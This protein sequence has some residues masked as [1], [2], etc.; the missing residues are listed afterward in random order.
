M[1]RPALRILPGFAEI[2]SSEATGDGHVVEGPELVLKR[3]D[4]RPE[5]FP[6]PT[7]MR[8]QGFCEFNSIA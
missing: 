5:L 3:F 4:R 6:S 7:I 8:V 1:R 2:F